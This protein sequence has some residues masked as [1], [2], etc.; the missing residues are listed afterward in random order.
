VALGGKP[1][2][3]ISYKRPTARVGLPVTPF[4]F[5]N[6]SHKGAPLEFTEAKLGRVEVGIAE[7]LASAPKPKAD[8]LFNTPRRTP[9]ARMVCGHP[10]GY[11]SVSFPASPGA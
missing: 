5:G 3:G 7:P 10:G 6:P 1:G 4:A 2:A 11:M 9:L 8:P